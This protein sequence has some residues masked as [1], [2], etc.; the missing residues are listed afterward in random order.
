MSNKNTKKQLNKTKTD[1]TVKKGRP[2]KYS[3]LL[4]QEIA[5]DIRT[6]VTPEV[7]AIERGISTTTYYDWM[8]KGKEGIQPFTDFSELITRAKYGLRKFVEQRLFA[9]HPTFYA[10][11]APN[12]REKDGVEGWNGYENK[13]TNIQVVTVSSIVDS[14]HNKQ[15]ID[16]LDYKVEDVDDEIQYIGEDGNSK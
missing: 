5:S 12:M 13:D 9:E 3:K 10:R 8:Q 11:H 1:K 14:A 4:A 6:G 7:A 15:P 2:T 16:V